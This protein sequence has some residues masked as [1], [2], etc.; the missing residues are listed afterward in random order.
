MAGNPQTDF[1]V[2]QDIT[3]ERE[4]TQALAGQLRFIQNI[5][6][7]VPG[8]VYQIRRYPD[9]S[10]TIPYVNDA[11]HEMVELDPN[12]L[13]RDARLFYERVHPDDLPQMVAS[14]DA[15]ARDLTLWRQVYRIQLPRA[16]L[17]WY[18]AEAVP[19][20]EAD[21]SVLWH[22][23]T[24]DV[25]EARIAAQALERQHRMLDAVRQAQAVFIEA[26]D[27]R[28]AF[29]GLLDAFL[30]VTGS[31]YGFVGEVM[32]DMREQPYLKTH[33]I[34]DIAWDEASRRLYD[35]QVDAGMEFRNLKTLFGHAMLTGETVIANDPAH[36]PRS[37]GLPFG[38][39]DMTSFLGIPIAVGDRLV[40]MVGLANQPGGYSPT[41]VE[42]LQPLLG[43]VRQL[44]LAW[45]GHAERKRRACSSRPR[46][47]CWSK[48]AQR[49][50]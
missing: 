10:S 46:V 44:V 17:R 30:S 48:K 43:A 37:G 34:T 29:E 19:Q 8:L 41:D 21:G 9:G 7:R 18:S 24:F 1:G 20:R 27:K 22:G 42:F 16:G 3:A 49:C 45:R 32:Y 2:V 23:F 25:T 15:S 39:P 26:D 31:G 6:A 38:H 47:P 35:A 40:A 36:D 50:K 4:A 5:A 11:V 13:A 28:H 14:L 33:A 12:D